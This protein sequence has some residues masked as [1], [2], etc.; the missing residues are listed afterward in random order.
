MNYAVN[1]D[2]WNELTENR[3]QYGHYNAK[4]IGGI[5]K[6]ILAVNHN[7]T[8]N[9]LLP[10]ERIEDALY[11][12]HSR[13]IVVQGKV[14]IIEEEEGPFIL[15][16]CTDNSGNKG[17]NLIASDVLQNLEG[18]MVPSDAVARTL[19]KWRKFW[20]GASRQ[21]FSEEQIKGLFGELWFLL[22]WLLPKDLNWVVCWVGP[23]GHRNDFEKSNT[24]IE[25]KTTSSIRGHIHRIN[26]LD[27]L[28]PPEVGVLYCFSLRLRREGSAVNTLPLLISKIKSQLATNQSLLELFEER[29]ASIGYS[30][31]HDEA[32]SE[33]KYRTIDERLYVVNDHFPRLFQ[34]LFNPRI[35]NGVERI[36]YDVNLEVCR[37]SVVSYHPSDIIFDDTK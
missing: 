24:A 30:S 34:S 5:S 19:E 22:V 8:R 14:L 12:N 28:D 21:I 11:D 31:V 32:Y 25:V 9:I 15:I 7:G 16:T 27:Q 10:V 23:C 18:G 4:S 36:D 35:P 6:I 37:E 17:F 29:L 1:E 26:G 13:G 2:M 20:G 33:Y 3:P